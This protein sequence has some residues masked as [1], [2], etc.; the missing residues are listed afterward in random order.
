MAEMSTKK[1]KTSKAHTPI[2][3]GDRNLKFTPVSP[4]VTS[5]SMCQNLDQLT[6]R[7]A[8]RRIGHTIRA[9]RLM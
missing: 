8:V 3:I 6:P 4:G 7:S 9:G 2:D 5:M 1:P